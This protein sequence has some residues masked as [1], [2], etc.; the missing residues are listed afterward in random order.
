MVR[1]AG[2][3]T[4][5]PE[6]KAVIVPVPGPFGPVF[7]PL[8]H[9]QVTVAGPPAKIAATKVNVDAEGGAFTIVIKGDVSVDVAK[10]K[11]KEAT[12]GI[13]LDW[14]VLKGRIG[15]LEVSPAFVRNDKG[16]ISGEVDVT[17]KGGSGLTLKKKF[18]DLGAVKF[19]PYRATA[20]LAF[21]AS[22]GV[23]AAAEINITKVGPF[24][25]KAEIGVKGGP[26]ITYGPMKQPDG[27]EEH[28][29]TATPFGATGFVSI[30]GE[31]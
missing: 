17:I 8:A 21:Q 18:G 23:K 11:F 31:F 27:R 15:E 30:G 24:A 25:I 12:Y 7:L 29:I 2:A 19:L 26:K 1:T 22:G 6:I 14:V 28:Q 10:W 3:K 5:A 13:G 16:E 4:S 9:Q 20:E